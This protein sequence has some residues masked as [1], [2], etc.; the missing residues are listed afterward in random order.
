M[1]R[2][3]RQLVVRQ[4]EAK[5]WHIAPEWKGK[6]AAI[7]G[8]GPSLTQEQCDKVRAARLRV[9][10]VNN[11]YQLAP[12]AEFLYFCDA[13]WFTW[14]K[15][16][17]L[18]RNFSGR[19]ITLE[20]TALAA[21]E[22]GLLSVKNFQLEPG[23]CKLNWGVHTGANSGYQALNIAL[24]LGVKKVVLLGF[25]MRV[26][27]RRTHWHMAHKRPTPED[28]FRT[29]MIPQFNLAAREIREEWGVEVLN[30][31]PDSALE[32]FPRV[33]LDEALRT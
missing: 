3:P 22:P 12:W 5:Y 8:G 30:C 26:V 11:A 2:G 14:H 6:T 24:H 9:I 4:D 27:G 29:R 1:Q 31:T 21:D 7:L 20:N 28:V 17:K 33:P 10:A 15:P 25:D 23:M 13:M 32:C 18:F 19:K 16:E